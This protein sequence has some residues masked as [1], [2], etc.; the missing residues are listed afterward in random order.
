MILVKII[1]VLIGWYFAI[2]IVQ[3][4]MWLVCMFINRNEP[5]TADDDGLPA[6]A[7]STIMVIFSW[8]EIM[9]TCLEEWWQEKIKK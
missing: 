1:I 9:Y 2:G 6:L 4:I 5:K 8:P 3:G 7:I